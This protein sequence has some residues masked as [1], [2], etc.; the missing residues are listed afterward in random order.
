M[1]DLEILEVELSGDEYELIEEA[2][3]WKGVDT[4]EWARDILLREARA[5]TG[6]GTL[7]P[8]P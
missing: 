3:A 6:K 8:E 7:N 5:E 4:W 1:N 2:A